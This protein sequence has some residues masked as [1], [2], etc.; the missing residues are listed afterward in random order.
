MARVYGPHA[1]FEALEESLHP[2][3]PDMLLEAAGEY[4]YPG[5]R[6]LDVGCSERAI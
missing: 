5:A 3:G 4:L 2:R 6:I 1:L